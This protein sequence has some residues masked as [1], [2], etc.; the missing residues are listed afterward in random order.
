MFTVLLGGSPSGNP[1]W[2]LSY[3]I[4]VSFEYT[5]NVTEEAGMTLNSTNDLYH[6]AEEAFANK[7][8]RKGFDL[9]LNILDCDFTNASAWKL[10]YRVL[11]NGKSFDSFQIDVATKYFPNKI[12]IL[13]ENELDQVLKTRTLSNAGQQTLYVGNETSQ[14]ATPISPPDQA[15]T[16]RAQFCPKCGNQI[17]KEAI[18]C[19]NCGNRIDYNDQSSYPAKANAASPAFLTPSPEATP[20]AQPANQE[21]KR[22]DD[23]QSPDNSKKKALIDKYTVPIIISALVLLGLLFLVPLILWSICLFGCIAFFVW[24][25][26]LLPEKLIKEGE[27]RH[28]ISE[29]TTV[30]LFLSRIAIFLKMIFSK[31][32]T[33]IIIAAIGVIVILMGVNA[34]TQSGI[35]Q[36]NAWMEQVSIP[37][38]QYWANRAEEQ[39]LHSQGIFEC[40]IGS[41]LLLIGLVGTFLPLFIKPRSYISRR[42]S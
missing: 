26:E 11:G 16:S 6:Q 12:H 14:P 5:F 22:A 7:N 31:R 34:F 27:Q 28:D 19:S 35:M 40:I 36:S 25:L 42:I 32:I 3:N 30:N 15:Q 21:D 37:A 18:Y 2:V 13:M 1:F 4:F 8:I 39:D 17:A 29:T 10:L 9:V 38:S 33:Y 20:S 23:S 41:A 24:K